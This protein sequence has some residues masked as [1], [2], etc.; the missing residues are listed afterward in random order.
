MNINLLLHK[1]PGYIDK[2]KFVDLM[3]V[4]TEFFDVHN[5]MVT[6]FQTVAHEFGHLF[7]MWHDF[8]PRHGGQG[9]PCDK[10]GIMSYGSGLPLAWSQCSVSD[11]TAHYLLHDWG[12]TC[13]KNW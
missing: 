9:G 13:L 5:I 1:R 6:A 12:N 2:H 4:S 3:V 10:K 11:F 7:G 8:D